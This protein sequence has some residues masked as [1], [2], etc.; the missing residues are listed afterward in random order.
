MCWCKVQG[1]VAFPPKRHTY[2]ALTLC[3][4]HLYPQGAGFLPSAIHHCQTEQSPVAK[5][6]RHQVCRKT[7]RQGKNGYRLNQTRARLASTPEAWVRSIFLVM[8]LMALLRFLLPARQITTISAVIE[9]VE[10]DISWLKAILP[11]LSLYR[12]PNCYG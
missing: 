9:Y 6:L 12:I 3:L 4:W 7:P 5:G 11:R 1:K 8:N 10:A 2:D